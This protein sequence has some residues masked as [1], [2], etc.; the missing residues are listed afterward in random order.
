MFRSANY[1]ANSVGSAAPS[2]EQD[3]EMQSDHDQEIDHPRTR[4]NHTE[5]QS[6]DDDKDDLT[7][8]FVSRRES[9]PASS[10]LGLDYNSDD[11]MEA[12]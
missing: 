11:D 1:A 12:A 6:E 9:L 4:R 10:A 8:T 2:D 7:K 3:V 5:T